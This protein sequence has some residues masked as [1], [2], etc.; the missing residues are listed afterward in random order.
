MTG[1][2]TDVQLKLINKLAKVREEAPAIVKDSEAKLPKYSYQFAALQDI[3]QV[4]NPLLIEHK[5]FYHWIVRDNK[6]TVVVVDLETGGSIDSAIEFG[7]DHKE[8]QEIG[9]QFTYYS[10]YLLLAIL[11]LVA[12]KDDDGNSSKKYGNKR[13]QSSRRP[14]VIEEDEED[15]DDVEDDEEYGEPAPSSRRASSRRSNRRGLPV[16]GR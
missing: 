14:S 5:L 6:I 13:Q 1:Q 16:R 10:R 3:V 9:K 4:L 12:E 15:Y 11:G 8:F 2:L 7:G